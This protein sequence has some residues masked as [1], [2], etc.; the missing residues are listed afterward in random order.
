MR[1]VGSDRILSFPLG[2]LSN[3]FDH[4]VALWSPYDGLHPAHQD[5]LRALKGHHS[6]LPMLK[7]L[8]EAEFWPTSG[9]PEAPLGQLAFWSAGLITLAMAVAGLVLMLAPGRADPILVA[10]CFLALALHGYCVMVAM[11][12]LGIPRYLLGIWPLIALA[13]GVA[14][15]QFIASFLEPDR[16]WWKHPK[17]E[18]VSDA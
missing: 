7:R 11:L 18:S 1:M 14:M 15:Q 12:G 17:R 3:T 10:S 6:N 13:L 4:Y 9:R 16:F 8:K 5:T 2:Y